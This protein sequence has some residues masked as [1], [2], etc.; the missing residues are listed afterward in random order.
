MSEGYEKKD[1][2]VKAIVIGSFL[3]V[4]LIVVFVVFLNDFF[5]I[6][7]EKYI[8]ENVLNV[9][10]AELQELKASEDSLLN[11]YKLI[12][13]KKGIY[14]IPIDQAMTVVTEEYAK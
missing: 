9:K 14:Q 5:I 10:S 1:V 2:S 7:K 4:L 8:Y 6:N 12:D 13:S 3:T 11:H